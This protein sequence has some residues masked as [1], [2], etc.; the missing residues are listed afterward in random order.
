MWRRPSRRALIVAALLLASLL[1]APPLIKF[2]VAEQ[3]GNQVNRVPDVFTPL[4]DA[5]RP[6]LTGALTFLLVGTDTRSDAPTTGTGAGGDGLGRDRSDVLMLA[7]VDAA[8]TGATI[9]SI[10]RDSWV[11]IPGHGRNKINSAYAAGG[12]SLLVQTVEGLTG[13]RVDHLAVIDFAGFEALVDAVDGIDVTTGTGPIV[14]HLDGEAA[15]K[16]VRQ[17]QA[18]P[19]GDLDR[20]RHEQMALRALLVKTMSNGA[21]TDPGGLYRL[22]DAARRLGRRRRHAH[23]RT[24]ARGGRGAAEATARS[25]A[26]RAGPDRQVGQRGQSACL[27]PRPVRDRAL[28]RPSRRHPRRLPL[29]A[30]H[31]LIGFYDDSRISTHCP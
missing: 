16:F 14:S 23:Q 1:G 24:S 11:D 27:L 15:L 4:E 30:Q 29:P 7:R 25:R 6:P 31:R 19:L 2:F 17:R 13:L 18:Q 21:L 26:V 28:V 3:I 9:V 8:R 22:L 12:P 20:V 5:A 10:P